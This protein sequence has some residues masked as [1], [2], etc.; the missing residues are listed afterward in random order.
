MENIFWP[1]SF[2]TV[3]LRRASG[4]LHVGAPDRPTL[5]FR[6]LTS[7]LPPLLARL[8]SLAALICSGV[9]RSGSESL[10]CSLAR[11]TCRLCRL[12]SLL[13]MSHP[14]STS[15]G[16]GEAY[17]MKK[18]DPDDFRVPP[19]RSSILVNG[20]PRGNPSTARR[21]S[22]SKLL[23]QH[24]EKL[25]RAAEPA[26]RLQS[27][28]AAADFSGDGRGGQGQRHQARDVGRQSA[29]MPGLQFQTSQR[30]G[31]GAR[32]FVERRAA[33][34]RT[35]ATSVSSTAPITRRC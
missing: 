33:A 24:I 11:A 15:I 2:L 9:L 27:L 16:S 23:R 25:Q 17:P 20:L 6:T 26:L 28:R 13:S 22:I 31:T 32:F 14:A 1:R 19:G 12:A 3:C 5:R 7:P 21:R 29:G 35:R 18:I 34:A 10:T 8:A 4:A 30:R